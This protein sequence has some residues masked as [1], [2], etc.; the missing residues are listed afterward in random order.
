MPIAIPS[1][2]QAKDL[3][4]AT[5]TPGTQG[6]SGITWGT[7]VEL[8]VAGAGTQTWKAFET[9]SD[10]N[11]EMFRASDQTVANYAIE[12][13][14]L[15]MII[16]EL[17]P[18]NGVGALAAIATAYDFIR[19]DYVYRPHW[20]SSGAGIRLVAIGVRGQFRIPYSSGENIQELTVRPVG[21]GIYVGTSTDS[22][23]I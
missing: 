15:T 14:D 10:P 8:S 12:Y 7:A 3:L 1:Y 21:Y 17:I 20:L 16:R 6:S 5:V 11:L 22:P 19:V 18:R 13:D 23:P 2:L 9:T 4:T